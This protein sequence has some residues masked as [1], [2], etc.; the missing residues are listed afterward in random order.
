MICCNNPPSMRFRVFTLDDLGK[1]YDTKKE[2]VVSKIPNATE[3]GFNTPNIIRTMFNDLFGWS[4]GP[5]GFS[6]IWNT[7]ETYKIGT[8][9]WYGRGNHWRIKRIV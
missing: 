1:E 9:Y 5:N 4:L 8:V 7:D 2:F 6:L 3:F